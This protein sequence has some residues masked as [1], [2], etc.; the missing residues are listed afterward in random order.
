MFTGKNFGCQNPIILDKLLWSIAA[1]RW[2]IL[3]V[4][5]IKHL[6]PHYQSWKNENKRRSTQRGTSSQHWFH[7]HNYSMACHISLLISMVILPIACIYRAATSENIGVDTTVTALF[8]C[9]YFFHAPSEAYLTHRTLSIFASSSSLGSGSMAKTTALIQFDGKIAWARTII[10]LVTLSTCMIRGLFIAAEPTVERLILTSFRNLAFLFSFVAALFTCVYIL[11]KF[12][13]MKESSAGTGD[14]VHSTDVSSSAMVNGGSVTAVGVVATPP[15][16]P[17]HRSVNL[18]PQPNPVGSK[19]QQL[20]GRLEEIIEDLRKIVVIFLFNL[21]MFNFIPQLIVFQYVHLAVL[22]ILAA[23]KGHSIH[24]F[25]TG[26]KK[27]SK[28]ST[29]DDGNT[30][31]GKSVN[32]GGNNGTAISS[33]NAGS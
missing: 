28:T 2:I 8:L 30:K 6:D 31:R 13:E 14:G 9:F 5:N 33:S 27:D 32:L 23:G 11:K 21:T 12:K 3:F 10:L 1:L 7:H 15:T 26:D 24:L 4:K 19:L 18:A 17:S 29:M 20:I 16:T 25:A 22:V